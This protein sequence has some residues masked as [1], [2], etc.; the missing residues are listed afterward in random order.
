MVGFD[1]GDLTIIFDY[2]Y[3]EKYFPFDLLVQWLHPS[4]EDKQVLNREMSYSFKV[5]N[6]KTNQTDVIFSRYK[7]IK[8]ANDLKEQVTKY[9]NV[10]VKLDIGPVYNIPVSKKNTVSNGVLIPIEKEY[11]IDIDISD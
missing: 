6:P 10:P 3:L 11:C 4:G 1:S 2:H 8:S 5:L 9:Q 7:S